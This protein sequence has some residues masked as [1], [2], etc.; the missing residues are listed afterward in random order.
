MRAFRHRDFRI[1]WIGAFLSFCGS[2]IQNVAQQWLVFDLTHD[3]AK[4][5]LVTFCGMVPVSIFGPFAGSFT[6]TLDKRK[7]LITCQVIFGVNALYLAIATH[8]GLI[9]FQQILISALINGLVG[10]VEMP[11]RQSIVSRVVPQEDLPA[12]VPLNAMTFNL[13]RFVGP[14][15]GTILLAQFGTEACYAA[16]GLSYFALVFSVFAIRADLTPLQRKAEP[17]LDLVLDGMR[18]TFRDIRLKTLFILEGI[19][20]MMGLFYLSI[21]AAISKDM[22]H[23]DAR[24]YGLATSS[25]GIGTIAGLLL[26]TRL[27]SKPLKALIVRVSMTL[28]G[29]GIVLLSFATNLWVAAPLFALVGGAAVAQFNTTNTLF[30]LLSPERMRGR[31]LSMHVWAL[32]GLAPPGILIFGKL[33]RDVSIPIALRCSG[34]CVLVGA[35]WGWSHSKNLVGV[36]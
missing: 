16:N 22:M 6:D 17:I 27:S 36:D 32:S 26:V 35:A 33:A 12:A 3:V 31:V 13:A 29:V 28:V 15:F 1:L 2:W 7:V 14:M 9:S 5:A 18:Y 19:T 4:L 8:Y 24:G 34:L 11:T 21:M 10:C 20:S 30:Q 23:L 25:V